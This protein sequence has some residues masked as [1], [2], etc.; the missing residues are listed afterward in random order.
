[1]HPT[2]PVILVA[3]LF[4]IP[5]ARLT[6]AAPAI[7]QDP[8]KQ[9]RLRRERWEQDTRTLGEA[10]S[11]VGK[12]NPR[13]NEHASLALG[14]AAHYFNDPLSQDRN[15]PEIYSAAKKAID[16]GCDDPLILYLFARASFPPNYTDKAEQDRRYTTA[17]LALQKSAY[18]PFR[19]IVALY[20]AAQA[21]ESL[22]RKSDKV[23]DEAQALYTAALKLL[24]TS[25][26]EDEPGPHLDRDLFET[27]NIVLHAYKRRSGDLIASFERVDAELAKAAEL[28]TVRLKLTGRVFID[29]AWE[30]RGIGTADTVTERGWKLYRER[31][32]VARKALTEAWTINPNDGKTAALMI[33]VSAALQLGRAEMEKW[34]ERAMKADGNNLEAC[35]IM[36]NFIEP[37]WFGTAEEMLAF[38]RACRDTKNW[39]AGITLLLAD[40]HCH[41]S[42]YL[43]SATEKAN[44]MKSKEVIQDIWAVYTEYLQYRPNDNSVRSRFAAFC[45]LC[46][47]YKEAHEQ[48][49]IVGD[50][51]AWDHEFSET[52]MKDTRARTAAYIKE[53][54]ANAGNSPGEKAPVTARAQKNTTTTGGSRD[55]PE[56]K[57]RYALPGK[58]WSWMEPTPPNHLCLATNRKGFVLK[59]SFNEHPSAGHVG[60][61]FAAEL[62]KDQLQAGQA[63]K[64]GGHFTAFRGLPCYQLEIREPGGQTSVSRAFIANGIAYN[65]SVVG[66]QEPI[67]LDAHFEDI[68]DG[69]DF[70]EPPVEPVPAKAGSDRAIYIIVGGLVFC[71]FVAIALRLALRP[72]PQKKPKVRRDFDAEI[73]EVLPVMRPPTA[74]QTGVRTSRSLPPLPPRGRDGLVS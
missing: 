7:P 46:S 31:I 16:A 60:E 37:K 55:F 47:C 72:P 69:F 52:W 61:K 48:F 5:V 10:Y 43:P 51:L 12:K 18:A 38:G 73:S 42:H 22:D 41:A 32:G 49:Q 40:A 33:T 66:K 54:Q 45:Y 64:R 70:T 53:T 62:D 1:M 59:V 17:A 56:H 74:P 23:Q 20:K 3:A 29:Y 65:V 4:A 36:R 63:T 19:R 26:A 14:I 57:C 15:L 30:A 27:A 9:E 50:N 8:E 68:M 71:L 6:A 67:E 34:F 21:R 25:A 2:I 24:A 39:R 13:W 44:Y 35:R 11:M 28:R 58:D